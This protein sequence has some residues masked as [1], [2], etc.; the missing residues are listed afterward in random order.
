MISR[1][2]FLLILAASGA[3]LPLTAVPNV[4]KEP[5][6]TPSKKASSEGSPSDRPIITKPIH[7]KLNSVSFHQYPVAQSAMASPQ[8]LVDHV[9]GYE[10]F[11]N[12]LIAAPLIYASAEKQKKIEKELLS[13]SHH[14]FFENENS[15]WPQYASLDR[16]VTLSAEYIEDTLYQAIRSAKKITYEAMVTMDVA[17]LNLDEKH[18]IS[19]DNYRLGT[20]TEKQITENLVRLTKPVALKLAQSNASTLVLHKQSTIELIQ[21]SIFQAYKEEAQ[22]LNDEASQKKPENPTIDLSETILLENFPSLNQISFTIHREINEVSLS[23]DKKVVYSRSFGPDQRRSSFDGAWL[24]ESDFKNLAYRIQAD[25][26]S[27]FEKAI[28]SSPVYTLDFSKDA[29]AQVTR[30]KCM[31]LINELQLPESACAVFI[32]NNEH[33]FSCCIQKKNNI[34]HMTITDSHNEDRSADPATKQLARYLNEEQK[35][36]AEPKKTPDQK[37]KE[38][39]DLLN[40]LLDPKPKQEASKPE[41]EI[42]YDAPLA[43][44]PL[45]ELPTLQQLVGDKDGKLPNYI[46]LLMHQLKAPKRAHSA[47][48]QL[49]NAYIFTGPPGTGKST[50]IQVLARTCNLEIV[51]AGGGD[52]RTAYQGS[53]KLKLDALYAY[54]QK[55][56][57]KTGKRVAIMIDEIDGTSSKI[58]PR[59]STEEDNRA[60]KSLIT[61]LDQHRYDEN[62]FFFGTTNYPD[63]IDPAILRRFVTIEIPLPTFDIRKKVIEYYCKLNGLE[64]NTTDNDYGTNQGAIAA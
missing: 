64:I 3:S 41:E 33:W 56:R 25:T 26:S 32:K 19:Y 46:E 63:K 9:S 20:D 34:F 39:T 22:K 28:L 27:P 47:G 8:D 48:T 24:S 31:F 38:E 5:V 14:H 6:A 16:A 7:I 52:F 51:Y 37:K 58:E 12:M 17:P 57:D 35:R 1:S 50:L 55:M 40:S 59:S 30:L 2:T 10:A 42:N 15:P 44:V 36:A 49:K 53:S 23:V 62:I 61:T 43:K 18:V 60:I 11:K 21:Q 45:A 54:A 13:T 29:P 4:E